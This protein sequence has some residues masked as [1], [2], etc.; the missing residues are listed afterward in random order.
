MALVG[1]QV[2]IQTWPQVIIESAV[3]VK[4]IQNPWEICEL[5]H[6]KESLLPHHYS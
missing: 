1:F 2:C 4:L 3:I 6:P 5:I